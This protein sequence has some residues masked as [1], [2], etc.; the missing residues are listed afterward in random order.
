MFVLGLPDLCKADKSFVV[1]TS[2][3]TK[4]PNDSELHM[5]LNKMI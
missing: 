4:L 2:F 5:L 3:W 1:V